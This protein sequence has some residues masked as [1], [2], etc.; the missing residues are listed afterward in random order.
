MKTKIKTI[1]EEIHS[2]NKSRTLGVLLNY[3]INDDWNESLFFIFNETNKTY[4]FFKT[5]TEM[6][7]Y[8]IG[9]VYMKRAYINETDFDEYYDNNTIDGKFSEK[10]IYS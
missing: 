8:L 4:T 2:N 7:D 6:F 1:H 9:D 3:S 10:L 5:M